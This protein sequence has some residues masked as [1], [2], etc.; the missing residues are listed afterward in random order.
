MKKLLLAAAALSL[1]AVAAPAHAA[2]THKAD[3]LLVVDGKANINGPCDYTPGPEGSFEV[4][5]YV[6]THQGA[7]AAHT[8]GHGSF[9]QVNPGEMSTWNGGGSYHAQEPLGDGN[10]HRAGACWQNEGAK[11]CAWKLGEPRYFVN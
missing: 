11:V 8:R 10:L 9:A 2:V 4:S 1:F 5:T 6:V 3:C 7:D